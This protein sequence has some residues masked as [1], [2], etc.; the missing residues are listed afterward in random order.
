MSWTITKEDVRK[1]SLGA[2]VLS[3]GGGGKTNTI[4]HLLLSVMN[5]DDVIIVK[6]INELM[7]EWVLP[8]AVVGSPVLFSEDLP[9][10][11]EFSSLVKQYERHTGKEVNAVMSLEIGGMNA[12]SPLIAALQTDLPVVDG[13]AMGRAFP[14]LDMTTLS[15]N[16][17]SLTPLIVKTHRAMTTISDQDDEIAVW[18]QIKELLLQDNGYA[19]FTGYGMKGSEV[20]GATVPGSLHLAYRLG[21]VLIEKGSTEKM[22]GMITA[23]GNS[24]YGS[25]GFIF[26]GVISSVNRWFENG[27]LVGV[28]YINGKD[29]YSSRQIIVRFQN[30]FLSIAEHERFICTSP[31]LILMMHS[32]TM[33]PYNVSDIQEGDAV[34]VMSVPAPSILR[35]TEMLQ[36]VGPNRFELGTEY[37]PVHF[38]VMGVTMQ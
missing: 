8:V 27:S 13:D 3:C 16:H 36:R 1:I 34:L 24:V 28:C 20:K 18:N 7:D 14:E 21:K 23:F 19:H 31:D 35:T 26:R 2:Q 9:T 11:T 30:E 32:E 29:A 22:K 38:D 37:D 5:E 17:I 12:I 15:L 25:P 4:E 10:G 33:F 6:A